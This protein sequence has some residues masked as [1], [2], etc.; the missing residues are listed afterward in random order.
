M[1]T[2]IVLLL[3]IAATAACSTPRRSE[4]LGNAP[5]LKTAAEER[6]QKVFMQNC[7]SCHVGG[8]GA[9]GP[10]IND[11]PLPVFAMR[12]QVRH[13]LGVMPAF[14]EEKT[15][16]AELDDLMTYLLALRRAG[17]PQN[18]SDAR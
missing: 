7:N 9:L 10:S 18:V 12:F 15:S 8:T 16:D 3:L 13:G 5:V 17:P 6:G 14:P 1:K 11:K 4:T 2:Y